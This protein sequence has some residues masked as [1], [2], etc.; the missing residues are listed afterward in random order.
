MQIALA[1]SSATT[2][3]SSPWSRAVGIDFGEALQHVGKAWAAIGASAA[4]LGACPQKGFRRRG[5]EHG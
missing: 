2:L 4:E 3:P 5:E 1:L